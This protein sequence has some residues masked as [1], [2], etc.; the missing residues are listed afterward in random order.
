MIGYFSFYFQDCGHRETADVIRGYGDKVIFV[1]QP[2]QS[3]IEVPKKEIKF[4]GYFK[5]ARHY[6]WALN[7]TLGRRG[8]K[9]VSTNRPSK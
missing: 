2:D 3:D 5:I 1:E 7:E 8:Y 4:K 6:G 9:Q